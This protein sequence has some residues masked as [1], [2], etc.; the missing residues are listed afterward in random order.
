MRRCEAR[1]MSATSCIRRRMGWDE[2]VGIAVP[3][4]KGAGDAAQ[5]TKP[6]LHEEREGVCVLN[7]SARARE[8]N[9]EVH[10]QKT[11]VVETPAMKSACLRGSAPTLETYCRFEHESASP[12]AR[13]EE[14][15]GLTRIVGC[16][17]WYCFALSATCGETSR[18]LQRLGII[19]TLYAPPTRARG[20]LRNEQETS[21]HPCERCSREG[22]Q[23][24]AG[25]LSFGGAGVEEG[26]GHLRS[27][28]HQTTKAMSGKS[29]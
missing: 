19:A 18:Q 22:G 20:P 23:G 6:A 21:A 4:A 9:K 1:G 26:A 3:L 24:D 13:D 25:G 8:E 2:H 5:V 16:P 14:T 17:G 10:A 11:A 7:R 15:G 29:Q 12:A 28:P 27:V